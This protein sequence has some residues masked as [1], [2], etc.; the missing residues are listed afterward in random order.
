MFAEQ[1]SATPRL[2]F[3]ILSSSEP[4]LPRA[5]LRPLVPLAMQ[6][7]VELILVR[8]NAA[9]LDEVDLVAELSSVRLLQVDHDASEAELRRQAFAAAEGD[10][11]V[12]C[13]ATD[14]TARERLRRLIDTYGLTAAT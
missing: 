11:V 6:H 14:G 5:R 4:A 1:L 10:I 8:A 9:E 3:V 13:R 2:T 12:F 7:G